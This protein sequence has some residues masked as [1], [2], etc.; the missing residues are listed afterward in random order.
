MSKTIH[1]TELDFLCIRDFIR[2]DHTF[3]TSN[4]QIELK[5]NGEVPFLVVYLNTMNVHCSK[6]FRRLQQFVKKKHRA[7]I[8]YNLYPLDSEHFKMFIYQ[9]Y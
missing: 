6:G 9:K 5:F 4:P 7:F 8:E 1:L 3:T 2:N